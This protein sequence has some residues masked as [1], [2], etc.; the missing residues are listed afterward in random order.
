M[1]SDKL[2]GNIIEYKISKEYLI[3]KITLVCKVTTFKC[4]PLQIYCT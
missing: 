4:N 1:S 2:Q 3:I